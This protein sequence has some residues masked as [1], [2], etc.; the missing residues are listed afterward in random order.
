MHKFN[1]SKIIECYSPNVEELSKILFPHVKYP[2]Q[3]FDRVLKGEANLDSAQI[4][5]LA[6]YL[7]V[8]VADLFSVDDWKG[9]WNKQDKC[10]TFV[11][12]PYRVNLNYRGSFI[13][14]YKDDKVVC[15]EIKA[16]ANSMSITDFIQYINTLIK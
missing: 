3:A 7:G 14:V 12:G 1:L 9:N 16:H 11:K 10:L 6:S 4:E 13:T 2:K 5:S 15:Q 8:F